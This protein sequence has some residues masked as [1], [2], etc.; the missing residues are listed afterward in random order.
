MT[1]AGSSQ[2]VHIGMKRTADD[3]IM[4]NDSQQSDVP[5]RARAG[6]D[7]SEQHKPGQPPEASSVPPAEPSAAVTRHLLDIYEALPASAMLMVMS[8]P[9]FEHAKNLSSQKR[10][11]LSGKTISAWTEELEG[12]LKKEVAECNFGEV[13]F[14][15]KNNT[16]DPNE[17]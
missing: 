12:Q 17:S 9:S 15:P 4:S 5:K 7:S 3:D 13:V 14:I 8:Q 10:A 11:C 16:N 2:D 6:S 1:L